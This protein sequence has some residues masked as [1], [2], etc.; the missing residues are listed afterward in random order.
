MKKDR[1]TYLKNILF[2]CVVFSAVTGIFTGSVVF[3]FRM[4][5]Q[6]LSRW[7]AVAYDFV[8]E[9]LHFLP[10]LLLGAALLGVLSWCFLKWI[11][12]CRGGGIP[13][14]I[15]QV[16]GALSFRWSSCFLGV[17]FSSMVTYLSGIPLGTEGPSV[18]MGTA[19]GR[20]AVRILGRKHPAWDRY[21]MTGGACSGFAAATGAPLTGIL[22]AFEEAHERFSPMLLMA[23]AMTAVFGSVTAKT[24]FAMTGTSWEL[25]PHVPQ[26]VLPLHQLWMPAAVGVICGLFAVVFTKSYDRLG[27]LI[28]RWR[29]PLIVKV[30]SVF[31]LG[32]LSGV[33]LSDTVGSGHHLTEALFSLRGTWWT[34]LLVLCVRALFLIVA[35]NVGITGGLFVPSLAFGALLGAFCGTVLV[36][37]GILSE[38]CL[39]VLVTVGMCSF[40]SASSRTPLMAIAFSLEALQGIHNILPVIS[41]VALA[42]VVI[43][44]FG[45]RGFVDSVVSRKIE[46]SQE[47][48]T[49]IT[50][51]REF[52]VQPDSFVI[53]KEI[54][55]VLWPPSCVV[56]S[57]DKN[58]AAARGSER[59]SEGDVLHLHYCTYDPD[60]TANA[61][62]DLVGK[63]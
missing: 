4:G 1:L 12:D 57:V 18:Q 63:R 38:E 22:F 15:G 24:L 10:L 47:G 60:V 49:P 33:F 14:A 34:L 32:T 53:G 44:I 50:V 5:A 42:Y 26:I 27:R 54:R 13:T 61:V 37:V 28:R 30:V 20:G 21:V 9:H 46:E 19:L 25:F 41:G 62:E 55:D 43:E 56:V 51:E 35:N 45:V 8:G 6:T 2:P 31:L 7:S 23:S 29:I 48:K 58:P 3:L 36:S 59:L 11:P 52:V 39:P 40:L 16:R 17:F